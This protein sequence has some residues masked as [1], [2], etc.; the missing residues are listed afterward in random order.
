MRP[1]VIPVVQ[2][3]GT[4]QHLHY[5]VTDTTGRYWTGSVWATR[6]R[7]ALLHAS[8]QDAAAA[9][10]RILL[11]QFSP[12]A[13]LPA[14]HHAAG[15]V[16]WSPSAKLKKPADLGRSIAGQLRFTR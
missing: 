14:A 16:V 10:H 2:T 3:W 5:F 6:Q 15:V 8:H 11:R 12:V 4:Q 1:V 13:R 7:D 9:D